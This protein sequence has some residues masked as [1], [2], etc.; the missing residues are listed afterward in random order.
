MAAGAVG[1]PPGFVLDE[2]PAVPPLPPRRPVGLGAAEAAEPAVPGLPPGFV[3]DEPAPAEAPAPDPVAVGGS[4]LSAGAGDQSRRVEALLR[5]GAQG[6]MLGSADEARGAAAASPL[7]GA[8]AAAAHGGFH[9]FDVFAGMGRMALERLN[10]DAHKPAP[11]REG[12]A[13]EPVQTPSGALYDEGRDRSRATDAELRKRHGGFFMGGEMLGGLPLPMGSLTAPKRLEAAR[14]G[15]V[16]GAGFGSVYGFNSG[17]GGLLNRI[18]SA[19]EAAGPAAVGGGLVGGV[20]GKAAAARETPEEIVEAARKLTEEHNLP[21]Q[22]PRLIASDNMMTQRLGQ[23]VR[24]VPWGPGEKVIKATDEFQTALG[25]GVDTTAARVVDPNAG[26]GAQP[27][28]PEDAGQRMKGA[29]G[30]WLTDG[31]K[32]RSADAY[33]KVG[34]LLDKELQI[35]LENTRKA[36]EEIRARR[37]NAQI[38]GESTAVGRVKQAVTDVEPEPPAPAPG[39]PAAEKMIVNGQ[40]VSPEV[41]AQIRAKMGHNGGPALES[42][43]AKAPKGARPQSMAQYIAANGGLELTPDTAALG[44]HQFRTGNGTL[45]RQGGKSLDWMADRLQAEGYIARDAEGAVA[46]NRHTEILD[47]LE[48]EAKRG[49]KH[50]RPQDE[51]LVA[52]RASGKLSPYE[53]EIENQ[54]KLIR[55]ALAKEGIEDVDSPAL[56][57]AAENVLRGHESDGLSAYERAVTDLGREMPERIAAPAVARKPVEKGEEL[58]SV[59]RTLNYAGIKDLR[60]HLGELYES[61]PDAHFSRV[62]LD[63]LYAS[64]SR[65]LESVVNTA[66]KPGALR[67]FQKANRYHRMLES[68]NEELRQIIGGKEGTASNSNVFNALKAAASTTSRNDTIKLTR[69]QRVAGDAWPEFVSGV[70]G[71]LGKDKAGDFSPRLFHRDWAQLSD[72]G[73]AVLFK[74]APAHKAAL[75]ELHKL[76][77]RFKEVERFQNKSNTASV[78]GQMA[79]GFALLTEPVT[80]ISTYVGS[81]VAAN[82]LASPATA[83]AAA[84]WARTMVNT[85]HTGGKA[86]ASKALHAAAREF[87]A[88]LNKELG[89]RISPERLAAP[90]SSDDRGSA[91]ANAPGVTKGDANEDEKK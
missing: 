43:P 48:Q 15:I 11:P 60:T 35:P 16:S 5:G 85:V 74:H 39:A 65:D 9:P 80:A 87:S 10:A 22:V 2:L 45:A 41:A 30:R 14:K 52:E 67:E 50:Y 71:T 31:S 62:E 40:E 91:S 88:T 77:G 73:K 83:P 38:T 89:V 36:V 64:L 84:K 21:V 70:V 12:P 76:S 28:V 24:Q 81:H 27:A 51:A 55:K 86:G 4:S 26:R 79:G 56:Y 25:E 17:E 29:V 46:R 63:Q 34:E 42:A 53:R 7:P 75:D 8:E 58:P 57:D 47:K 49:Q 90:P 3:L 69:A 59:P 13:P 66:G 54:A 6:G 68:R 72:A 1:L 44:F 20:L 61:K 19:D 33:D 37:G 78:G 18:K 32:K 23:G 82:I